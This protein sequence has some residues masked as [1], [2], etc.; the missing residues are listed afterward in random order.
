MVRLVDIV[1]PENQTFS[2]F[3]TL[4]LVTEL[5]DHDIFQLF[6][7]RDYF[8]DFNQVRYIIYQVLCGYLNHNL[9][10]NIFIQWVSF[11]EI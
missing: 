1:Y 2:N 7:T 8:F 4:F 10:L 9:D 6:K 5:C 11:T 3:T